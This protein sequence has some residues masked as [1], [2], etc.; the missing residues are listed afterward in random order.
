M[1]RKAKYYASLLYGILHSLDADEV[2]IIVV[3]EPPDTEEW[4]AVRDRLRR[5][6]EG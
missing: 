3:N 6:S 4:L 2:D 1:P 5:A